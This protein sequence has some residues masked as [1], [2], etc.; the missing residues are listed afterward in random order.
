MR[1]ASAE[2]PCAAM[3]LRGGKPMYNTPDKHN[4]N[5]GD[6]SKID[7]SDIDNLDRATEVFMKGQR[8]A[9]GRRAINL[10]AVAEQGKRALVFIVLGAIFVTALVAGVRFAYNDDQLRDPNQSVSD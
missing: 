2:Q 3:P 4:T 7:F 10:D 1:T 8:K 5:Q 9:L 6:R